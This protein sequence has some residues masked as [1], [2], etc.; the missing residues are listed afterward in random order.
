MEIGMKNRM[1]LC[2]SALAMIGVVACE[3]STEPTP[4]NN[5]VTFTANLTTAAEVPA[6]T[7]NIANAAGTFTAILDT[8][9]N[10]LTYDVTFSGLSSNVNNGHIH[11]PADAGVAAGALLNFNTWP[12]A[13]FSFGLQNGTAHGTVLLTAG[14][15]VTNTVNGD[16]LKKLLFAGKT[17]ANIHT[18]GNTQGEIRGQITKVP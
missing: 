9:T 4:V 2:L 15:T 17:Y 16:S 8:T 13:Q 14:T 11:G 10:V 18:T 6:P 5:T 12:Q 3:D 7:G 1:L